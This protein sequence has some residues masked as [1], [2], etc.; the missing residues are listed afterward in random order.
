MAACGASFETASSWSFSTPPAY[1]P[2]WLQPWWI[3]FK[4]ILTILRTTI[5]KL[6]YDNNLEFLYL[7]Q[8][9]YLLALVKTFPNI[10]SLNHYQTKEESC[11]GTSKLDKITK[12][13]WHYDIVNQSAAQGCLIFL[14]ANDFF[15]PFDDNDCKILLHKNWVKQNVYFLFFLGDL[16]AISSFHAAA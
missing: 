9:A 6:L 15:T 4:T 14:L 11:D 5:Q 1:G 3:V 10:F 12:V 7:L 8:P 13:A 2:L 16:T